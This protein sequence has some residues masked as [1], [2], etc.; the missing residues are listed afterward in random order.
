MTGTAA[1]LGWIDPTN[2][3]LSGSPAAD[4]IMVQAKEAVSA[5]VQVDPRRW[6][7]IEIISQPAVDSRALTATTS[8]VP[9]SHFMVDSAGRIARGD[10]WVEQLHAVSA[11]GVVR[12][13][14]EQ[15][16]A[17]VG[18]APAQALALD[19]IIANLHI[20]VAAG[21]RKMPVKVVR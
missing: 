3:L 11:P 7:R 1:L 21:G 8:S 16:D 20:A 18:V 14:L 9:D 13:I 17:S 2:G 10:A 5:N 12:V 4:E 15:A 6:T 19:E